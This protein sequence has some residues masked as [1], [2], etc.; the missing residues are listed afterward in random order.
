MYQQYTTTQENIFNTAAFT[1]TS[2]NVPTDATIIQTPEDDLFGEVG[3]TLDAMGLGFI[4]DLGS[5]LGF[6]PDDWETE[7]KPKAAPMVQK[8]INEAKEQYLENSALSLSERMTKFDA[9]LSA[10]EHFETKVQPSFDSANSK[11]L[12]KLKA[13]LLKA[14]L[15][16]FRNTNSSKFNISLQTKNIKTYGFQRSQGYAFSY[17]YGSSIKH[18]VYT[19]KSYLNNNNQQTG[20][21]TNS[22]VNNSDKQNNIVP[23]ILVGVFVLFK[24]HIFK[25]LGIRF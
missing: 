11:N 25:M 5:A 19:K 1:T 17:K 15:T 4:E 24:K 2:F 7:V 22:P 18:G 10:Y 9:Y 3:D 14:Y 8:W 21:P 20:V 23:L 12:A 13:A 6:G 16:E